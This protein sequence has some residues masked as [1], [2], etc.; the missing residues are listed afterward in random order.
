M[1]DE[2][3]EIIDVCKKT[4]AVRQQL[5]VKRCEIKDAAMEVSKY[6]SLADAGAAIFNSFNSLCD[7]NESPD[8]RR[9]SL[10]VFLEMLVEAAKIPLS[11]VPSPTEERTSITKRSE[12]RMLATV[13]QA[14]SNRLKL[15][16]SRTLSQKVV[17]FDSRE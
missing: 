5:K 10:K 14:S 2:M 16:S 17:V 6:Q 4:N 7:E 1:P 13:M 15:N 12:P 9:I 8:A 11:P 3:K